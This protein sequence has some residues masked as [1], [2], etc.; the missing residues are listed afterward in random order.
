MNSLSPLA[1]KTILFCRGT[2]KV[3]ICSLWAFFSDF[4]AF[5]GYFDAKSTVLFEGFVVKK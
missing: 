4:W 5:F 1:T 3:F 2:E